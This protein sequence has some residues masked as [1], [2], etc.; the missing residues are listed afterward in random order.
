MS[1]VL[2][3]IVSMATKGRFL[4]TVVAMAMISAPLK[5]SQ[6]TLTMTSVVTAELTVMLQESVRTVP[7]VRGRVG[8]V[9]LTL[10]AGTVQ[11]VEYSSCRAD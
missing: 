2:T 8:G 9:T 3:V 4:S 10:G 7:A 6:E 11:E 5:L 1:K